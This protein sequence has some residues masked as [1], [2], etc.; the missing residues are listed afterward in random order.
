MALTGRGSRRLLRLSLALALIVAA[1]PQTA[2]VAQAQSQKWLIPPVDAP[3]KRGF[4]LPK[5]EFGPGNRG[6]DYAVVDGASVRAAG[7]GTVTFAGPVP[8]TGAVTIA[9]TGGLETTYT[10]MAELFVRRGDRVD[11]GHWIGTSG[12][13]LHF[14]VKLDDVY[15]DPQLY[16]GPIELGEAIH[17]IP[18]AEPESL[19]GEETGGRSTL[20]C[21]KRSLLKLPDYRDAPNDNVVV[22]VGGVNTGWQSGST[23]EVAGMGPS[24]GYDPSRSY[25]FSYSDDPRHYDPSDTFADLRESAHRLDLLMQRI[26]REHP[27]SKVDILAHSQGGLV[28]RYYLETADRGWSTK[29]PAVEHLVTLA[30]PHLGAPGAGIVDGI[31]ETPT[32]ELALKGLHE[33]HEDGSA[34]DLPLPVKIVRPEILLSEAVLNRAFDAA[35]RFFPDPYARSIRQ[36]EPDSTF[37]EDLATD[38]IVY[39]TRVLALQGKFDAV[40]PADHALFPGEPNRG[41]DGGFLS[42]IAKLKNLPS[43]HSG[44]VGDSEALAVTHSFLRGAR[45][46]C[47]E[48]R[49]HD[50]WGWGRR[51]SSATNLV[52]RVW[53]LAEEAALM[54]VPIG[55]SKNSL[56]IALREGSMLWKLLRS[57]GI[58]GALGHGKD[59]IMDLGRNPRAVLEWLVDQQVSSLLK[60]R[61]EEALDELVVAPGEP[62][63]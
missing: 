20:G 47:L 58:R 55:K 26:A 61:I 33:V 28:A 49:D 48:E 27:G 63:Q 6:V 45:L 29:R 51:L 9:H 25:V 11:Q 41:I 36:M 62:G 22:M 37:L 54:L 42:T 57:R 53:S 35:S 32:G 24:L 12:P 30:T 10:G 34:I 59:R 14:G 23:E 8:G 2:A 16:L 31:A 7:S 3:I 38:D 52:P 60:G 4:E 19:T 1:L 40:V 17:L 13:E 44:I 5:G 21:T 39:G 43:R 18:L 15:V 50:I 46:P 56:Q